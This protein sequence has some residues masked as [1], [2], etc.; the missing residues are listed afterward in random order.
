MMQQES[1]KMQVVGVAEI[2]SINKL[3]YIL[4]PFQNSPRYMYSKQRFSKCKLT[5]IFMT[6]VYPHSRVRASE[7]LHIC[8]HIHPLNVFPAV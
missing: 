4:M 5:N 7:C 2:F 1:P 6:L 3:L 8:P